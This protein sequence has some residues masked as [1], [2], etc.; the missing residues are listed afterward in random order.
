MWNPWKQLAA[1]GVSLPY[2]ARAFFVGSVSVISAEQSTD[3]P[4]AMAA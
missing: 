3:A 2:S 4:L 1:A